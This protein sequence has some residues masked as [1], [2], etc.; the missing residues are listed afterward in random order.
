MAQSKDARPM[1]DDEMLGRCHEIANV[2]RYTENL[3]EREDLGT[4]GHIL[5]R[6]VDLIKRTPSC[7][8]ECN[9]RGSS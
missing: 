9:A 1:A 2:F 8:T 6:A 5:T 4:Y 7:W 3:L